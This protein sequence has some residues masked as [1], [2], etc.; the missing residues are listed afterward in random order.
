MIIA[1]VPGVNAT[2]TRYFEAMGRHDW[3]E[4]RDCLSDQFSRVGPYEEHSWSDPQAY[5]EFLQDLL[6]TVKGQR[7]E[8]TEAIEDGSSVHVNGTETIEVD[9]APHSVRVAGSFRMAPDDKISHIEVF[10]RRLTPEE[11]QAP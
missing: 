10:V 11:A 6:P 4:L 9:G 5:V 2:I 1:T 7:L 3:S 8:L